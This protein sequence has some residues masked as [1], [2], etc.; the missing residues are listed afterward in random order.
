MDIS[1][2]ASRHGTLVCKVSF[3][4]VNAKCLTMCFIVLRD[5]IDEVEEWD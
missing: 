4:V 5:R 1:E 2:V 3:L